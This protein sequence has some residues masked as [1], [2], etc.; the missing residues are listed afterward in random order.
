MPCKARLAKQNVSEG[1]AL[2]LAGKTLI[3]FFFYHRAQTFTFINF[4]FMKDFHHRPSR[5]QRGLGRQDGGSP[6]PP[7]GWRSGGEREF[8]RRG[9]GGGGGRMRSRAHARR[10]GGGML[11]QLGLWRQGW[12]VGAIFGA[13]NVV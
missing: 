6:A 1:N 10:D 11:A 9:G 13:L 4:Y 8:A 5:Q 7:G 2:I 12:G 3:F